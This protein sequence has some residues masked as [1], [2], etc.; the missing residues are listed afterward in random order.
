MA[1]FT[2][3]KSEMTRRHVKN[4]YAAVNQLELWQWLKDFDKNAGDGGGFMF[5]SHPN[6]TIIGKKMHELPD[7]P[8]HSG[9]SFAFTMVHLQYI[10]KNGM[11]KYK[12]FHETG[13]E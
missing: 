1:D 3:I 4:G 13:Q 5:N 9:S 7:S 2:F 10:A 6:V 11:D 8:E 12:N